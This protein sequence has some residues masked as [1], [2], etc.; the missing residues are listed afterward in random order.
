MEGR[1]VDWYDV[2]ALEGLRDI[3]LLVVDGITPGGEALAPAL[4]VLGRRLAENAAVV[5]EESPGRTVP[6][7]VGGF[8]LTEQRRLAG[9]WI[10]LAAPL[11]GPG[12]PPAD[13]GQLSTMPGSAV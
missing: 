3:D 2:D 7:Q 11:R 9:R 8:G 13:G 6:R 4:H 5:V 1:T 12:P 10:T